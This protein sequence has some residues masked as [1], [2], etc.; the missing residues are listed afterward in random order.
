LTWWIWI[1]VGLVLLVVEI[2]TPGGF[3]ALFFG[4]SALVVA[5]L[6]ALGLAAWIQWLVFAA[7]GV[8]LLLALRRRLTSALPGP[9]RL[10]ALVGELAL[11][12]DDL[13]PGATGKAELR[14]TPWT[15]FNASALPL[16]R[17]QRCRV[18]RVAELVLHIQPE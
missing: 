3:F 12:L 7:L 6:S 11:P 4:V 8:V 14:G 17:G 15:A 5:A 10:D 1:L 9:T 16:A 18:Q 2:A 13:A